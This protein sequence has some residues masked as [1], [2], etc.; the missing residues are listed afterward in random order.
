M[1]TSKPKDPKSFFVKCDTLGQL[2]QHLQV[3]LT[4][5]PEYAHVRIGVHEKMHP[6]DGAEMWIGELAGRIQCQIAE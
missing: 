1:T 2:A 6:S 4:E 3:I 5:M